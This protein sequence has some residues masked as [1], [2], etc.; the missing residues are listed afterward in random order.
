MTLGPAI[1]VLALFERISHPLSR[2]IVI[3]GRVPLFFYLLHL[4]VIHAVAAVFAYA[5][6][7]EAAW[8]FKNPPVPVTSSILQFPAHYGYS[9]A[10]V[11]AVWVGVV[12]SLYPL[13]AWFADIK[14][15]RREA[16]LSY[17]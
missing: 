7:G 14:K 17:L 12:L 13:C 9:L 2:P 4:V 16:C 1:I 6:Y 5:Q 10:P 3:L 11:Y 15:R 8:M